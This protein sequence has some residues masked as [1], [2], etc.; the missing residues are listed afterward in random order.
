MAFR[1]VNTER[2]AFVINKIN[3]PKIFMTVYYC[4]VKK[5]K[6]NN[7]QKYVLFSALCCGNKLLL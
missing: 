6:E 3:T 5:H 4:W 2:S 1:S 7:L